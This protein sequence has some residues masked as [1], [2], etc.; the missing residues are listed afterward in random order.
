MTRTVWGGLMAKAA[1]RIVVHTYGSTNDSDGSSA[2]DTVLAVY[3]GT[4]LDNLVR[5]TGNDNRPLPGVGA[6]HSLVQFDTVAGTDYVV[7][8]G[9][10]AQAEGEISLNVFSF[11][12]TGGLSAFLIHFGDNTVNPFNGRDYVCET[13]VTSTSIFCDA[14][15]IVHNSTGRTLTVTP[16]TTL[17]A[18]VTGPAPFSLAPGELKVAEFTVDPDFYRTVHTVSGHFV[19]TGRRGRKVVTEA[20]HR[21]LIVVTPGGG[22]LEVAPAFDPDKRRVYVNFDLADLPYLRVGTPSI[23]VRKQ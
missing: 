18:G 23:A 9:S 3:R 6:K 8:I 13:S 14:R 17:D 5:V 11:P 7:Q 22:G 15:F 20:R 16:S 4:A 2:L 12:A 10:R 21:A 19:F 1:E